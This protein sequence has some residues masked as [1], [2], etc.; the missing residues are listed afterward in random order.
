MW[1]CQLSYTSTFNL[2]SEVLLMGVCY[3]FF[4]EKLDSAHFCKNVEYND[5][6]DQ[7]E[8]LTSS[9]NTDMEINV[10]NILALLLIAE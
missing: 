5:K 6:A 9:A 4:R 1:L 10:W 3:R 7:W 8:P 2:V